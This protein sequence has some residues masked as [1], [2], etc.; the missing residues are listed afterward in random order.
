MIYP[1]QKKIYCKDETTD[2]VYTSFITFGFADVYYFYE[3]RSQHGDTV[4]VEL[5]NGSS[6]LVA[7]KGRAFK[8]WFDETLILYRE[9]Q[10]R[11]ARFPLN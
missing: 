9:E 3:V 11:E 10:R 2:V 4:W 1:V 8:K 7:E 6:F 5:N